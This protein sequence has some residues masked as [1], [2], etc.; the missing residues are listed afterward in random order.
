M[1]F[2]LKRKLNESFL[3]FRFDIDF[4]HNLVLPLEFKVVSMK[5]LHSKNLQR[6]FK[7]C[8]V[9]IFQLI[10]FCNCRIPNWQL[11]LFNIL[12]LQRKKVTISLC[13]FY[14]PVYLA[15]FSHLQELQL[16]KK[17]CINESQK[18]L[19]FAEKYF[20]P[21]FSSSSQVKLEKFFFS[22]I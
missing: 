10:N 11:Y 18:L 13:S 19:K 15:R 14:S 6:K 17:V 9:N 2:F 3:C 1:I 20:Y 4:K 8:I 7:Q 22:Q 5:N 16:D 12:S 21:T